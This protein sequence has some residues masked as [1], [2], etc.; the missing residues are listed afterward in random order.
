MSN[1][2]QLYKERFEN[3]EAPV[4]DGLWDKIENDSTW[5]KHK[6][7]QR[8]K[9][10]AYYSAMAIV[11]I[12]T[13]TALIL[14]QPKADTD[15][16]DQE[17]TT[18]FIE[19][20]LPA[21]SETTGTK[22]FT[23]KDDATEITFVSAENEVKNSD[24][25]VNDP[26]TEVPITQ[27]NISITDNSESPL[28]TTPTATSSNTNS[29]NKATPQ[30]EADQAQNKSQADKTEVNVT[31]TA[32]TTTPSPPTPSQNETYKSPFSIPNAFTPNGDGINDV[33]KPV[34]AEEIQN[35]QLDI[36]MVNG[37]RVFSSNNLDYGWNGEYKGSILNGGTYVYVVKY[38]DD[39]G[40][41]HIDKGQ[42][43]LIR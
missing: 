21:S 13:C 31:E 22:I 18:A 34:T 6:R 26:V 27:A 9:N 19:E 2:E 41:E 30:S 16:V 3:F 40:K 33:F 32:P 11:S 37:Q 17:V 10:L 42:L 36:F 1:I 43:L 14:H 28:P 29:D 35:Y 4:S 7:Q 5:Q 39:T 38:R 24:V 25:I 15:I 23:E 20:T 12:G 8:N